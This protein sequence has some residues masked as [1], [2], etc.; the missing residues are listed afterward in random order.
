VVI[1]KSHN[2]INQANNIQMFDF[3]LTPQDVALIKS[4]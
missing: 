1:P 2:P 4:M 3:T